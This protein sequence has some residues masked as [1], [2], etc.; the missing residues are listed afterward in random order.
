MHRVNQTPSRPF[1]SFDHDHWL[2]VR[3]ER[4]RLGLPQ[5]A[6]RGVDEPHPLTGKIVVD[7]RTDERYVVE[8]VYRDW[9]KGWFQTA[10]LNRNG[11]HRTCVV[12]NLSCHDEGVLD[13]LADFKT[14]FQTT[15]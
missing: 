5:D 3:A 7:T 2:V 10:L 1:E 9:F 6:R 14:H 8:R 15:L 13:R 4:S 12:G 11:S